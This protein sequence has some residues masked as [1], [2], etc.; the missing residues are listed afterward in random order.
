M[1]TN[2]HTVAFEI[3]LSDAQ[4]QR[5]KSSNVAIM[6]YC[7]AEASYTHANHISFP[8]QI[9]VKING[10]Q[11]QAN[12]R[13]LKKKSGTT[14][15]ADLTSMIRKLPGYPNMV[16]ITYAATDSVS[17]PKPKECLDVVCTMSHCG[18]QDANGHLL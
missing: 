11:L 12:L 16:S 10:D 1:K 15:P 13:G 6:L 14:R 17:D 18:M 3:R 9:E 7:A 4:V 5:L 8:P 2:R